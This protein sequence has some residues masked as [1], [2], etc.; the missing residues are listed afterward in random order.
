MYATPGH[1]NPTPALRRFQLLAQL[2]GGAGN[3]RF[4]ILGGFSEDVVIEEHK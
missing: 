3:H 1:C 2:F 4:P